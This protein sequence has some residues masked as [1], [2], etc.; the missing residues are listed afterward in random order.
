MGFVGF[1]VVL[2]GSRVLFVV[3]LTVLTVVGF[4]LLSTDVNVENLIFSV[5]VCISSF[6]GACVVGFLLDG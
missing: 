3:G 2:T 5:V 6:C 1:G 4:L